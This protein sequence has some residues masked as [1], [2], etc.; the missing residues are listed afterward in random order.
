M[1][2]S[3][4]RFTIYHSPI[5]VVSVNQ[6]GP[7]IY[8]SD[9]NPESL[10]LE[11]YEATQNYLEELSI[12]IVVT[13]GQGHNYIAG[14]FEFPCIVNPNLR[15]MV[16]SCRIKNLSYDDERLK[17]G[18]FHFIFFLPFNFAEE[19]NNFQRYQKGL[20]K[21]IDEKFTFAKEI[22]KNSIG[23]LKKKVIDYLFENT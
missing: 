5:T 3:V 17:M 13:I 7:Y 18:Y 2:K 21:L 22:N 20:L 19:L 16:I 15:L 12:N 9:V 8:Y 14:V 10:N 4:E 1:I 11:G 23:A 6:E